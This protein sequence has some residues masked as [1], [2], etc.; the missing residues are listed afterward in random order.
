MGAALKPNDREKR[1][2]RERERSSHICKD[3]TLFLMC[4]T[5]CGSV[6]KER[7]TPSIIQFQNELLASVI[8]PHTWCR[9]RKRVI[10]NTAG[11]ITL[12]IPHSKTCS[13]FTL[14]KV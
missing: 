10:T 7:L 13:K 9:R 14:V 6:I 8:F 11:C 12:Y 3:E 2:R 5:S 4:K 1:D